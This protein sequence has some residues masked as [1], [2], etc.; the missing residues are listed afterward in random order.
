MG[1]ILD[2]RIVKKICNVKYC[3]EETNPPDLLV[4]VTG[5]VPSGG[6][7][8]VKLVRVTN[9]TPPEDGIQDYILFAVPPP[10]LVSQI[11]TPVEAKNRLVSYA[12]EAP[13]IKGL[14]V[15]GVDNCVVVMLSFKLD[16][17]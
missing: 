12:K 7:Y 9:E 17:K 5:E 14:R 11:I 2:M 16:P 10:D 4:E 15:H 1:Q 6:F 3:Y 13:W 8:K